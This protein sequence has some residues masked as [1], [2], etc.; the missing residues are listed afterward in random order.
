M[1]KLTPKQRVAERRLASFKKLRELANNIPNGN[2]TMLYAI[3]GSKL[4]ITGQTVYNY[5]QGRGSDGYIIDELIELFKVYS[6]DG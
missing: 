1:K 3:I 5:V 6:I 2:L 4:G